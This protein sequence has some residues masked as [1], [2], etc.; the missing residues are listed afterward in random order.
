MLFESLAYLGERDEA[1]SVLQAR[2][3]EPAKPG[4][5][6]SWGQWNL[7]L[8]AL[9]GLTVLGAR[10]RAG[11]LYPL[12]TEA[13]E[14]AGCVIG[15]YYDRRLIQRAAGIAAM[16]AGRYNEAETHFV[17]ALE[18][19]RTVPHRAE[20]GHTL[21]WFGQF[22]NEHDAKRASQMLEAAVAAYD[23]MGM[24]RHREL[25]AALLRGC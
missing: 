21:R 20:E 23:R 7:L 14:R 18:Q 9:E 17:T 1:L 22:L 4:R 16:R 10:P 15:S 6:N 19:S 13:I 8:A 24:R 3:S 25:T 12:V 11:D 5:P 2:T